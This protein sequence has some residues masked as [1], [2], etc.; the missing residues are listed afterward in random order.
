MEVPTIPLRVQGWVPLISIQDMGSK[1]EEEVMSQKTVRRQS[2]R[3]KL[4]HALEGLEGRN[5]M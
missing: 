1:V 3:S 2:Q 5:R 4:Y